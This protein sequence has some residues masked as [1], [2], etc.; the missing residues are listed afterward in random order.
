MNQK[1]EENEKNEKQK[2]KEKEIK[3]IEKDY[4]KNKSII[5]EKKYVELLNINIT[6]IINKY[7]IETE[8]ELNEK[9]IKKYKEIVKLN[10]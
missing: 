6:E 8:D 2:E 9:P 4:K 3:E 7:K 10:E 5:K 1:E